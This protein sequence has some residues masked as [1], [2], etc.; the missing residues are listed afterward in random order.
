MTLHFFERVAVEDEGEGEAVVC[1]HGLG[2][3]ANTWTPL[4]PALAHHRVIRVELPGSAR[5]ARV[6]GPLSIARLV[7][8][9]VTACERLGVTHAHW[10]G[11][12]LGTIVCQHLAVQWPRMVRTLALFGPLMA[13]AEAARAGLRQRALK[14]RDQGVAGQ[15]EV[16]LQLL[17]AALSRDTRERSPLAVA[18]VRDTLMRSDPEGYART[19]EALADAVPATVEAIRVPVLLVTGDEDAVSPPQAMRDLAGRL[20]QA[21]LVRQVVLPRCGHWT[22]LER[23]EACAREWRE[24]AAA[25]TRG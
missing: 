13:P 14:V 20:T 8:A 6:E 2:G 12:S 16:A 1:L 5:S 17:Q 24:F 11:H 15:H 19:C 7:Q 23:P 9:A 10:L 21:A 18:C 3:S 4:M 22:P 25:A